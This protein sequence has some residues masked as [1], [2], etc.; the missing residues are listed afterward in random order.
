MV[1]VQQG[2][3]AEVE[4]RNWKI[5]LQ[6]Q[7]QGEAVHLEPRTQEND[8]GEHYIDLVDTVHHKVP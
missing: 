3:E 2:V 4:K 8:L 6:F 5:D 7:E 1:A